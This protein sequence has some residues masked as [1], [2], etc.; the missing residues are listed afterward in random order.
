MLRIHRR[1]IPLSQ[2][3]IMQHKI[4]YL[5]KGGSRGLPTLVPDT[6]MRQMTRLPKTAGGRFRCALANLQSQS[7]VPPAREVQLILFEEEQ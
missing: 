4:R 5:H 2:W 1:S 3:L 7:E 6:Q